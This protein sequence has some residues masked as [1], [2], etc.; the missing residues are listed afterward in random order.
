MPRKPP[1]KRKNT[2]KPRAPKPASKPKASKS[3]ESKTA[4]K[5]P[6]NTKS[7]TPKPAQPQAGKTSLTRPA[8]SQKPTT[9][10]A[11]SKK[12]DRSKPKKATE[13]QTAKKGGSN[14]STKS[15]RSQPKTKAPSAQNPTAPR[16]AKTVIT[17]FKYFRTY[18][19]DLPPVVTQKGRSSQT[20]LVK[21]IKKLAKLYPNFPQLK[22]NYIPFGS[23]SRNV[24]IYPLNDIDL[25]ILLN[26][27]D[28]TITP[29]F[30]RS[31]TVYTLTLKNPQSP[32]APFADV[33]GRVNSTKILN[34]IKTYLPHIPH[35]QKAATNKRMQAVTFKLKSHPWTFDIVPAVPAYGYGDRITHYLIPDGRGN[36]MPTNPKIDAKNVA[37]ANKEQQGELLAVIRLLKYWNNR[38]HKPRL[39]SYYFETI[40]IQTFRYA[41]PIK[42]YPEA[43]QYFFS[44]ASGYLMSSCPDPKN[45]G[46]NLDKGINWETKNK[47]ITAFRN[48]AQQIGYAIMAES[49]NDPK[50]AIHWWRKVFGTEFPSYG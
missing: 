49:K 22:G 3:K 12:Q 18:T 14:T 24:K 21:Q 25:L 8:P 47:V 40:V 32:L 35:Y 41:A 13:T 44:H 19:V 11:P 6:T 36:W 17:A 27:A 26:G 7:T 20:F 48:A 42:S 45:L 50:L 31:S 30:H 37:T 34:R 38:I 33:Q 46:D 16:T 1:K 28:I 23:F 2:S 9:A 15:P 43:L 39:S 5:Q 4:S 10:E 29:T